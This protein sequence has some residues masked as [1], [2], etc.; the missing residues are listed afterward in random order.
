MKSV[1]LPVPI[2]LH[3]TRPGDTVHVVRL[4]GQESI[5]H[6]LRE[7]GFCESAEVRIINTSSGLI[8]QVCGA[9]VCLSQR[10]AGSIFVRPAA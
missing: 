4:D 9:R 10:L 2:R 5:C 7:M 3:A 1:S 8:C 6:R